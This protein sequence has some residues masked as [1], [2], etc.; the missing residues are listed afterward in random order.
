MAHPT[1]GVVEQILVKE[2]SHVDAGDL[3]IRLDQTVPQANLDAVT[4]ELW[5]L[6]ARQARLDAQRDGADSVTFPPDL[7]QA[8]KDAP[9][10]AR[11]V[12]GEGRLFELQ[13]DALEGQKQQLHERVA[14]LKN[15]IDGLAEQVTAK[16]TEI[17]LIKKEL[18]GVQE[19]WDKNLVPITR[20][21]ALQR[22][23]ARLHGERGAL[24]ASTAESK[25]KIAET[26]LQTI[27]LDEN[28]RSDVAKQLADIRS[29]TSDL[30]ERQIT[31]RE[32]LE[33]IEIR[34]PQ[35]GLVHQLSVHTKGAV[36]GPGE[37][38]MLIVPDADSLVAEVHVAPRDID[39]VSP[40]QSAM[41]RFPTFNQ[42][43]TPEI[44]GSVKLV[45]A[46]VTQD[47]HT[48]NAYYVVRVGITPEEL[49]QLHGMRLIPGMP[50][51]VFIRTSQRTM[52]SYLLKPLNDQV[53]RAFRE[54]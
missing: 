3:L 39:Q 30:R 33:R 17:D 36:I 53:E 28:M 4:M 42:R 8:A 32:Q 1:G 27:Q 46:D 48:G 15:Q 23:A 43:T 35:K 7:L 50:V 38:V 54:K 44:K 29:K 14:Q 18:A 41:L 49:A 2:G 16:D 40:Q 37:Q 24:T 10:I 47:D 22:D 34:A 26:Q 5:E 9:D 12:S 11:I 19:L 45:A 51:D 21:T 6:A 13:R 52:L 25:E 20:V 31:A